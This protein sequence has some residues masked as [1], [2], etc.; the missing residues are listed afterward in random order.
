MTSVP[1]NSLDIDIDGSYL[2]EHTKAAITDSTHKIEIT[3]NSHISPLR[4]NKP[5]VY[6]CQ[7]HLKSGSIGD[8]EMNL[9]NAVKLLEELEK[10]VQILEALDPDNVDEDD[11]TPP[12]TTETA[13]PRPETPAATEK[14]E[15][16]VG[17]EPQSLNTFI[18]NANRTTPAADAAACTAWMARANPSLKPD[19]L[20][21]FY[22]WAER[23]LNPAS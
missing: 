18:S 1:F 7:T 9:P 17:V 5:T 13:E 21:I 16:W 15:P 2:I 20:A 6:L 8:I 23:A 11:S 12:A 10:A 22:R 4:G 19:Q 3:T 14:V